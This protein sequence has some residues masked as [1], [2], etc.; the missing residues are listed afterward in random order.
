MSESKISRRAVITAS[1]ATLAAL[2]TGEIV[3]GATVEVDDKLIAAAREKL[4][5]AQN[6]SDDQ[7]V[8]E[9]ISQ[10]L[11]VGATAISEKEMTCNLAKQVEKWEGRLWKGIARKL[12]LQFSCS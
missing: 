9:A 8:S 5:L 7:V 6:S 1:G 10:L 4:K 11:F 12:K 2:A 3:N